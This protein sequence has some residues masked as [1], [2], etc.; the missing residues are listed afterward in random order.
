MARF[1][2]EGEWT[3]YTSA[4]RRVAH[5]EVIDERKHGKG[6]VE[7][8]KA[9]RAIVYTDGTSLLLSVREAKPREQIKI[10]NGYGELVRDAIRHAPGK[11]RVLVSELP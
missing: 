2:L 8:I 7:K 9:L 3:G 1:V 5:R 6:F 10:L 4:Q 11:S